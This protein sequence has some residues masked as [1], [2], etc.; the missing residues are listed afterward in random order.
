M[1]DLRTELCGVQLKNPFFVASH[2]PIARLSPSEHA[3]N[4]ARYVAHGAA[5]VVTAYTTTIRE[6]P[7]DSRPR[8]RAVRVQSRPPFGTEGF[9]LVSKT[10]D[11][12]HYLD[13][14]LA[15]IERLRTLVDVPIVA[16]IVGP[17]V[18]PDGWAEHARTFERAGCAAVELNVSC[19][20]N[21]VD[22]DLSGRESTLDI[23]KGAS[24]VLGQLSEE[25]CAV[26][27]AVVGAVGVPVIVKMTPEL[28]Y[29]MLISV[30]QKIRDAGAAGVT[31]INSPTSL[32]PPDIYN[33][34]RPIYPALG[35]WAY[36]GTYG[37]WDRFITY[38]YVH[39]IAQN[40][41][42]LQISAVGGNVEPEH[43][44][45][46]L[47]LGAQT[48]QLSS[49]AIWRGPNVVAANLRFIEDFMKGQGYE[50]LGDFRG[51]ALKYV[52]P[53][54]DVDFGTGHSVVDEMLCTGCGQC[55]QI[56]CRA[57][58]VTER[59]ARV[60]LEKCSGCGFCAMICPE[61]AL[62]VQM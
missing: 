32:A 15:M 29:P 50:T 12:I 33:G 59:L 1:I 52:V 57:V 58:E 47:M 62:S 3:G 37:P 53:L 19:P 55:A 48:V 10:R 13:E 25:L 8:G 49:A 2:A 18:D 35:T 44:I 60:N 28:G 36:G 22:V 41:P 23:P 5:A 11:V 38:K 9:F 61:G 30:A 31:V 17:G 42:G 54:D 27:K 26:T 40:V 14:T 45:E 7:A 4:L 56:L 21:V 20:D 46:F 34:G 39:A 16:N 51:A 43:S 6:R 24:V